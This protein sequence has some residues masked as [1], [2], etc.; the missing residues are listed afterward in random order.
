MVDNECNAGVA[1]QDVERCSVGVGVGV[2]VGMSWTTT[3]NA[4]PVSSFLTLECCSSR[5]RY[6][7][8][9]EDG[10]SNRK[11]KKGSMKTPAHKELL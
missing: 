8:K 4:G 11:T 1:C 9:D 6:Q 7:Q 5:T 3:I 10:V 2:D